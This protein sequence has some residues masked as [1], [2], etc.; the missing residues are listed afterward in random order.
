MN[1]RMCLCL[2]LC[3]IFSFNAV[4]SFS[5]DACAE[6]ESLSVSVKKVGG[7]IALTYLLT[8][9]DL[10]RRIVLSCTIT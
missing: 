6:T 7:R 3:I 9:G 1:H 10:P 4:S 2:L 5:F 8:L